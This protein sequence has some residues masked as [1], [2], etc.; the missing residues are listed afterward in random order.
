MHGKLATVEF[1]HIADRND[2]YIR[3]TAVSRHLLAT[4]VRL[5]I[6]SPNQNYIGGT[7]FRGVSVVC[8]SGD[9]FQSNH[10]IDNISKKYIY[11]NKLSPLLKSYI[12]EFIK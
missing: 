8:S 10:S 5:I 12:N 3:F 7:L 6:I 9:I 4:E 1:S 11:K 2:L